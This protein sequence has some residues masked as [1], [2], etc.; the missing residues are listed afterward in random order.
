MNWKDGARLPR[1]ARRLLAAIAILLLLAAVWVRT[2]ALYASLQVRVV[3]G[4]LLF[5][6][7]GLVF[8][9][10]GLYRW[11][12]SM[13]LAMSALSFLHYYAYGNNDSYLAAVQGVLFFALGLV[14]LLRSRPAGTSAESSMT[15]LNLTDKH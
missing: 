2:D 6:G 15:S 10:Y 12:G 13:F 5:V 7:S 1:V 9:S 11:L 4:V 3:S 14:W 8:V